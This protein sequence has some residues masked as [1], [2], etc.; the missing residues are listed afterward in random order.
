MKV[1]FNH[2]AEILAQV[3]SAHS[4]YLLPKEKRK[5][6][7]TSGTQAARA[8]A[9]GAL[10]HPFPLG[11]PILRIALRAPDSSPAISPR[12]SQSFFSWLLLS[13]RA[14]TGSMAL[15]SKAAQLQ[16]K[17]CEATRFA[18]RHGCAYQRALLEKNN[19]YVVDPPTIERCQDLSK[20]LFYT[21]L[22]RYVLLL[23]CPIRQS[24]GRGRLRAPSSLMISMLIMLSLKS[25]L[26]KL[27]Y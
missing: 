14:R 21:R 18:A 1:Q 22:A 8:A 6:A 7:R 27:H 15:A 23:P 19:K 16:A 13:P 25:E 10:S 24:R 17:A 2:R 11:E 9:A 26:G 12:Q 5:Q 4:K 3:R 20:Q